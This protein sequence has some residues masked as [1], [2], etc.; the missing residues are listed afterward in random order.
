M[1]DNEA[2]EEHDNWDQWYAGS[3]LYPILAW[4]WFPHDGGVPDV[5]ISIQSA[6]EFRV[7]LPKS[8]DGWYWYEVTGAETPVEDHGPFNSWEIAAADCEMRHGEKPYVD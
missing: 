8:D 1:S 6:A 5:Y 7:W 4:S 3:P 2:G